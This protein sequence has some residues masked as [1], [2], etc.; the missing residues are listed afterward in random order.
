VA[1][2]GNVSNASTTSPSGVTV[3]GKDTLNPLA[4]QFPLHY[5]QPSKALSIAR[6]Q[7]L[8]QSTYSMPSVISARDWQRSV[9]SVY[10]PEGLKRRWDH[11]T[12][13]GQEHALK[14]MK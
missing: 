2:S 8:P 9:A 3:P 14:R 10:D 1:F 12:N 13:I 7:P 4:N 5:P 6:P 11:A